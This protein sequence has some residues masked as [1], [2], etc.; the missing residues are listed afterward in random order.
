MTYGGKYP[1]GSKSQGG[2]AKYWRGRGYFV[3]KI[4]E[5][6]PSEVAAP[7]LCGGVTVYAPLVQNGVGPGKRVGVIGIGGERTSAEDV[8]GRWY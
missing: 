6:I 5:Q 4:P 1:D 7:M 8:W 3:F 2:Y